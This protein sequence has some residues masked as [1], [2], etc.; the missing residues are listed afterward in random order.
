MLTLR[1]R[2][3]AGSCSL[4]VPNSI[5]LDALT[6]EVCDKT[7]VHATQLLCGFPPVPLTETTSLRNGD[8]ITI[9]AA[10]TERAGQAQPHSTL[11]PQPPQT[12]ALPSGDVLLRRTI[13]DDNSCLFNA[14]GYCLQHSR[15]L[16]PRLRQLVADVVKTDTLTWS[17]SVLGKAS[18]EYQRWICL[19]TSWGGAIELAILSEHFGVAIHAADIQTCRVDRYGE[20]RGHEERILLMYDGLHYDAIVQSPSADSPEEFDTSIF[21]NGRTEVDAALEALVKGHHKAHAYTD[22]ATFTLRCLV[23]REGLKGQAEAVAHAQRTGHQS[24]GEYR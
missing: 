6:R 22:T 10:Q 14:V 16:A 5:S 9:T 19:T 20:D 3:S 1:V 11:P 24:Y 17:D 15:E 7:G 21:P 18:A 23:C 2:H 12:A 4:T 13:A 8:T